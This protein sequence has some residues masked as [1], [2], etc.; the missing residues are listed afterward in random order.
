[1]Q[2]TGYHHCINPV[3]KVLPK[4]L[5][6]VLLA[7]H[8]ALVMAES[9]EQLKIIDQFLWTYSKTELLPHGTE[10]DGNPTQQPIWLTC[11]EE[12]PNNADILLI[13]G[14]IQPSNVTQFK[15]TLILLPN[16]PVET[17]IWAQSFE[18]D[19][20]LWTEQD[21]GTWTKED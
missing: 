9:A 20:T 18:K 16:W 5:E 14:N 12:N 3:Q 13:V 11:E 8:R 2:I 7:K 4:L 6:K 17:S 15:K 19:F 21:G 1:M 10:E